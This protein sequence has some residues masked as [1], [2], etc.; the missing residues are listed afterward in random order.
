MTLRPIRLRYATVC[1]RC[2]REL[3]PGS[4]GAWD[5]EAR[6]ATCVECIE[7]GVARSHDSAAVPEDVDRGEAGSSAQSRYD[8]LRERREQHARQKLGRLSGA[9]LT[10]TS[11]PQTTQAWAAGAKGERELG[12]FLQRLDDGR[13]TFVLHDR[14]MPGSRA[15]ID[16]LVVA[17]GGIFVIDAKRY[18]GKVRRLDRGG[19]FSVD[20]RLYVGQRDCTKLLV[21]MDRQVAAVQAVLEATELDE[22]VPVRPVLCF[23]DA[24]WSLF[25]R[26]FQLG[27][28]W[29]EWPNSLRERIQRGGP[30]SP[31]RVNAL[32]RR[33]GASL[34][35]A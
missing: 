15:N 28:V 1:S 11:E 25:A 18:Q 14:R 17:A 23:V 8:R 9:Y 10:L 32:A 19:W 22:A 6:K 30:L 34:R 24:E 26:P 33:L 2:G 3:P 16:H 7:T 5:R 31:Q 20:E 35:P 13:T 12:A 4:R 29:V 27:G 21:Q